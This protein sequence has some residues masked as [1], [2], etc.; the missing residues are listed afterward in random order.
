MTQ[1]RDDA[2][3]EC[4][5]DHNMDYWIDD[6]WSYMSSFLDDYGSSTQEMATVLKS[7]QVNC[8]AAG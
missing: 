5:G 2:V 4:E 7:Q 8:I 3:D 1:V 6:Q